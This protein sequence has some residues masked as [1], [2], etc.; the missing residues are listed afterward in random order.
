VNSDP[1]SKEIASVCGRS[2][3]FGQHLDLLLPREAY[4]GNRSD[5]RL[6]LAVGG[7]RPKSP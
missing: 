5:K 4:M 6:T 2:A 7:G 3:I 1:K